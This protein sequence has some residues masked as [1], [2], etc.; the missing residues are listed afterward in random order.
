MVY[1]GNRLY[2][3]LQSYQ[4][5]LNQQQQRID[6]LKASNADEADIRKQARPLSVWFMNCLHDF[7][8]WSASWNGANDSGLP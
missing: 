2:K 5:E 6:K 8:V 3:E 7:V 4:K 1:S